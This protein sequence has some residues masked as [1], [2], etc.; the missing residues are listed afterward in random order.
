MKFI[1]F[2]PKLKPVILDLFCGAGGL[3]LGFE[4][5]NYHIGLGVEKEELAFRTHCYNFGNRCH[6]GDI[7]SITNPKH[8]VQEFGLERVDVI[9]GGPPCQGFS[10]VGRGKMRSLLQ[11]PTYIHDPRNQ[12]YREFIRFIKELEPLYFVMENVPDMQ[13][14]QEDGEEELLLEKILCIFRSMGYVVEWQVLC[15]AHFGVPQTRKRLFIL[16]TDWVIV[17]I[18][19]IKLTL[20]PL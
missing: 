16:G 13:Y 19:L 8:F 10:R 5:A 4:M 2:P 15:A 18:G 17:L 6:L 7:R 11:D 12:Y 1:E 20:M 3:S 14:Y 9:I